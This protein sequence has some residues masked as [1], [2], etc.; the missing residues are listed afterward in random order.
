MHTRRGFPVYPTCP[1]WFS[2]LISSIACKKA[3]T[4]RQ[5]L[6]LLPFSPLHSRF[7]RVWREKRDKRGWSGLDGCP[8]LQKSRH[9]RTVTTIFI[10][11]CISI[12]PPPLLLAKPESTSCRCEP[13]TQLLTT[14]GLLKLF[15]EVHS[16]RGG[17]GSLL[18]LDS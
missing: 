13:Q 3:A 16:T 14:V 7:V 6:A 10:Y 9:K 11:F 17:G 2:H 1:L 5:T 18:L 4:K 15:I 8:T 12:I